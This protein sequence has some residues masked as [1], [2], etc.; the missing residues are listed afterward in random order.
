MASST[1]WMVALILAGRHF[2]PSWDTSSQPYNSSWPLFCR[3]FPD[4]L[5]S[6]ERQLET[7]HARFLR[8]V[9]YLAHRTPPLPN[10]RVEY[11]EPGISSKNLKASIST[12]TL[13]VLV[14]SLSF[15][16][17]NQHPNFD[18]DELFRDYF[19]VY[20]LGWSIWGTM[21]VP[22]NLAFNILQFNYQIKTVWKLRS[23]GTLS[24]ISVLLQAITFTLLAVAQLLRSGDILGGSMPITSSI[25]AFVAWFGGVSAQL[26]YLFASLGFTAL[27]IAG[28]MQRWNDLPGQV[29]L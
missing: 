3:S 7:H 26:A 17:F 9:L 2:H 10:R 21:L 25:E 19:V 16:W 18:P 4:V 15:L 29:K 13:A 8:L 6:Y 1:A 22:S 11:P 12:A 20:I 5:Y 28:M 24:L 27:F 14:V 23:L